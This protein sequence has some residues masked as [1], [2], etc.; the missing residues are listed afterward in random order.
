MRKGLGRALA[1]LKTDVPTAPAKAP[2]MTS[3]APTGVTQIPVASIIPN[4]K[5]PRAQFHDDSLA[6]LAASIRAV[7]IIQPLVVRPIAKDRYELIAGERR[8]RA[9]KLAGLEM[10]PAVIHPADGERSLE[11]ALIENIQREDISAIECA[12]AYKQLMEEFDLTQE[13]LSQRVGRSRVSIA[14]T[15][16][17][18]RLPDDI[19]EAVE[20]G[21]LTEGQVRPLLSLA[22]PSQQRIVFRRIQQMGLSARQVE[23]LVKEIV[24]G[25]PEK[26]SKPVDPNWEFLESNLSTFFGTRTTLRRGKSGKGTLVVEYYNE[27]DLTRILDKIG[28]QL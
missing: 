11:M 26:P 20:K 3:T 7:G 25:R 5:Q 24:E 18:L 2:R 4:R 23:A 27:D 13:R 15:L 28:L 6:E 12:R 1:T 8:L 16:R 21:E 14:N 10:V 17:L 9:S 19:Q 22:N